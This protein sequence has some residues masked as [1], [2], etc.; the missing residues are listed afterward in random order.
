MNS[1]AH[2]PWH[3]LLLCLSLFICRSCALKPS[4]GQPGFTQ[5]T[6]R[7][8]KHCSN[9]VNRGMALKSNGFLDIH[10]AG[11]SSQ[12]RSNYPCLMLPQSCLFLIWGISGC[13][14]SSNISTTLVISY[15]RS[16]VAAHLHVK[17]AGWACEAPWPVLP[18][19]AGCA[20]PTW[21]PAGS[22][23]PRDTNLF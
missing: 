18:V 19:S 9:S 22:A 8:C 12:V 13:N 17:S 6:G 15:R 14:R 5:D 11:W 21:C 7:S 3:S 4:S 2:A 23:E 20:F 16:Q 1:K 10:W